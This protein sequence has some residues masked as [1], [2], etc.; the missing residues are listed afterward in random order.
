VVACSARVGHG[1]GKS[2]RHHAR[3]PGKSRVRNTLLVGIA[4]V[5]VAGCASPPFVT[6]FQQ[7]GGAGCTVHV[8]RT[9]TNFH[10]AN[11]EKPF[12]YADDQ[13]A[14]TLG[15]G[16]SIC[17]TLPP[18]KHVVVV[19]EPILFMPGWPSRR[20]E[21]E[22]ADAAP[23]YVRYSREFGGVVLSAGSAFVQGSKSLR[24]SDEAGWRARR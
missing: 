17:L 21:I 22:V 15:V 1:V 14:G 24:I 20:L 3:R 11:P 6:T 13:P 4:A 16:Q 7:S 5:L 9:Q 18:G 19:R 23:I 8:Y 10:S 12:V 2:G